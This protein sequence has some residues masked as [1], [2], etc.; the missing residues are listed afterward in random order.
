MS[1]LRHPLTLRAGRCHHPLAGEQHFAG[2]TG[3]IQAMRHGW[4]DGPGAQLL[5]RAVGVTE[6]SGPE[7]GVT[8]GARRR[9]A[10]AA[11]TARADAQQR[12]ASLL[13][14]SPEDRGGSRQGR[15][16]FLSAGQW[17]GRSTPWWRHHLA[18]GRTRWPARSQHRTGGGGQRGATGCRIPTNHQAGWQGIGRLA[19]S[20]RAGHPPSRRSSIST[21]PQVFRGP[22]LL[23][24]GPRRLRGHPGANFSRSRR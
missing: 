11:F 9:A 22:Q 7:W 6:G 3:M 17:R 21:R 19:A 24:G 2:S 15:R 13:A 20:S 5:K 18:P 8:F 1:V 16:C 23:L 12:T 4:R 10:W 14:Q